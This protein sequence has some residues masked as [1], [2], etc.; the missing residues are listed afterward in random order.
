MD[1]PSQIQELSKPSLLELFQVFYYNKGRMHT[2]IHFHYIE[3]IVIVS[4]SPVQTLGSY[5]TPSL[6]E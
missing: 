6:A 2:D 3:E 5:S 4:N 1:Q